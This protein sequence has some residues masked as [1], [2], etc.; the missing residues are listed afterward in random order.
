REAELLLEG[1]ADRAAHR[2]RLPARGLH[3][4][5]D[6]G[7]LL[8]LQ[9]IEQQCLLGVGAHCG[10]RCR[11]LCLLG[12][13]CV[14]RLARFTATARRSLPTTPRDASRLRFTLLVCRDADRLPTGIGDDKRQ[15]L[16]V[17]ALT[18][19]LGVVPGRPL[20]K[21]ALLEQAL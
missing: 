5:S 11:P 21:Q 14:F 17:L 2:V 9:E 4:L 6:A 1:A 19:H 15:A 18:P 20:V 3:R 7:T 13:G 12:P 8:A 16:T 10:G